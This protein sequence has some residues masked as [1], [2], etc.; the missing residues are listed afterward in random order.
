MLA[1]LKKGCIFA[2][3]I[4][5]EITRLIKQKKSRCCSSVWLECLPVTQEVASSSLVSTAKPLRNSG[6]FF[7]VHEITRKNTKQERSTKKHEKSRNKIG[8]R[9]NTKVHEKNSPRKFAKVR[10]KR[11]SIDRRLF[12]SLQKHLSL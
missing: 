1:D 9:K 10:E 7:C 2:P 8:P 6:W 12:I 4:N 11:R 5:N 3:V